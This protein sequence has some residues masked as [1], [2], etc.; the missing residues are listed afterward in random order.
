MNSVSTIHVLVNK[1]LYPDAVFRQTNGLLQRLSDVRYYG[2]LE[3]WGKFFR[4]LI[5]GGK[6]H[7]WTNGYFYHSKQ[8]PDSREK[9]QRISLKV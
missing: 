6:F 5:H 1:Y 7:P 3:H 4:T 8:F 2:Y 9:K